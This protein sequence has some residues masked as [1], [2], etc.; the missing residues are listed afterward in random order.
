MLNNREW[1]WPKSENS[2]PDK[3]PINSYDR[4]VASLTERGLSAQ[5]YM[6]S[7]PIVGKQSTKVVVQLKANDK[8][9]AFPIESWPERACCAIDNGDYRDDD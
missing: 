9:H 3:V 6:V 2:M 7:G 8:C 4:W 5:D 1:L